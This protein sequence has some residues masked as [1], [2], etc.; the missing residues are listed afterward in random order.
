MAPH[1]IMTS[2]SGNKHATI[3]VTFSAVSSFYIRVHTF[4]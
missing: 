3:M 1:D 2:L 4:S